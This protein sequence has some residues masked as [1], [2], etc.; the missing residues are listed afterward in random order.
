MAVGLQEEPK[1]R[2]RKRTIRAVFGLFIG[3]LALLTLFGNTLQSLTLPKVRTE[4][5][6]SGSLLHTLEGSGVLKPLSEVKLA[7]PAGW[8]VKNILV[9]EGDRVKK[10]QKL[11][12]YD[13]KSAE[14]ELQDEETRLAKQRIDLQNAQDLYIQSASEGDE[15]K[16]RSAGRDI[17]TRKLDI[18]V[19]ERKIGELR[20]RLASNKEIS[21]PF[22]GIVT[23]LNA[24]E[25]VSSTGEPDVLISNDS[26][27][28]RFEFAADASLLSSLSMAK[29][30]KIEVEVQGKS[31]Q[32]AGT[33][34]GT[35][36][37]IADAEP[38]A[39]GAANDQGG[40]SEAIAQKLLRVQVTDRGLKGGEQALVK[41][42]QRSLRQGLTITSEAVHEDRE[43]PF[44]YRIEEQ[45]GPL[46]NV[47]VVRKARTKITESNG[48][49]TM[50]ESGSV[51]EDDLIIVESSEPLQD[52]DRVRLQ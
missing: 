12:L 46:G 20:D 51:Y 17:E 6:V 49:E 47:F 5:P 34:D 40:K 35:I 2:N 4:K 42:T 25:G 41:L 39:G 52:G 11:I 50:I 18:G 7:N 13:S 31:D 10:G 28:Y 21:A 45:P 37:D 33:I 26:R 44:I 32:P 43:G 15:M 27:G 1:N 8:K 3:A 16:V 22:D 30:Q 48:R 9:K 38:R 36:V 19:Q 24:I 14:R 29:G 23:K